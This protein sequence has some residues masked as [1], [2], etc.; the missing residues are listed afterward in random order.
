MFCNFC[1][2]RNVSDET[3]LLEVSPDNREKR[4]KETLTALACIF[5]PIA[6]MVLL[7]VI[8]NA[9]LLLPGQS[10][11]RANKKAMLAYIDMN[12][13]GAKIVNRDYATARWWEYFMASA[14]NDRLEVEW[15]GVQFWIAADYGSVISDSYAE[16]QTFTDL[17]EL[18]YYD[19][20]VEFFGYNDPG[21][22]PKDEFPEFVFK[23]E[24]GRA[25]TDFYNYDGEMFIEINVNKDFMFLEEVEWLWDFYYYM[26]YRF[27]KSTGIDDYIVR[28]D[29]VLRDRKYKHY[30]ADARYNKYSK[31]EFYGSF[32]K[33]SEPWFY[34]DEAMIVIARYIANLD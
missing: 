29:V 32:S 8:L 30:F 31:T 12:Y 24:D 28:I 1:G 11:A 13:S 23:T 6:A 5:G 25:I 22:D 26:I 2:E 19:F 33:D 15:N 4:K 27:P 7:I 34:D 14:P 3:E 20:F 18:I 10:L 16:C 17:S 21:K 9:N